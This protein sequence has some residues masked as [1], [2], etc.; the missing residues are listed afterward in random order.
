[1]N[2]FKEFVVKALLMFTIVIQPPCSEIT[3]QEVPGT[4]GIMSACSVPM[5]VCVRARVHACTQTQAE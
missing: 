2:I 4:T 3:G 5:S 1:M